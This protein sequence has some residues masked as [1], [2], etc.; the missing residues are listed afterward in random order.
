MTDELAVVAPEL[1][2]RDVD[3]S[4]R[5]YV[6]ALGFRV[7]RTD[8]PGDAPHSFAVLTLGA[9]VFMLADEKLAG[10]EMRGRPEERRGRGIH[11]RVMVP[12]V[13][14]MHQRVRTQGVRI[15]MPLGDRSYGLRDFIIEDPDGFGV[16]F[17]A[18]LG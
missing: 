18:P 8:P 7:A 15:V 13:D 1:F 6:D 10:P 14:A 11:V 17:A 5:F 12:D 16:R 3:A 2:V 4:I 9:A